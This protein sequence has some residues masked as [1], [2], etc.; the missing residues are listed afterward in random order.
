MNTDIY[1]LF[2]DLIPVPAWRKIRH[3]GNILIIMGKNLSIEYLNETA[4]DIVALFTNNTVEEICN[5]M[6]QNYDVDID[7]IRHDVVM[8]IRQLQWKQLIRLMKKAD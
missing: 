6:S 1:C 2:K 5:I 3:D 8:L 7:T 4:N